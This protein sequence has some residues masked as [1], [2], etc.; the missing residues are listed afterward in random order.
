MLFTRLPLST[1]LPGEQVHIY[2]A[3]GKISSW[4]KHYSPGRRV[5]SLG[6][7]GNDATLFVRAKGIS[8]SSLTSTDAYCAKGLSSGNKSTA[9]PIIL[10]HAVVNDLRQ[11]DIAANCLGRQP[12]LHLHIGWTTAQVGIIV[13]KIVSLINHYT[14]YLTQAQLSTSAVYIIHAKMAVDQNYRQ[15]YQFG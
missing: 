1:R 8:T 5:N 4:Y 11:A 3:A 2:S 9:S 13:F 10:L 12:L 7:S 15:K 6:H 14:P